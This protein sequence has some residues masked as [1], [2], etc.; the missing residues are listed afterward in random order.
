MEK[1]ELS[2]L[3]PEQLLPWLLSKKGKEGHSGPREGGKRSTQTSCSSG[4]ASGIRG[5]VTIG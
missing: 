4:P 2:Q 1:S 5:E 3:P